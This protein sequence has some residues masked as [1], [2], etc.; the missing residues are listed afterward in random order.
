MLTPKLRELHVR[1]LTKTRDLGLVQTHLESE[2]WPKVAK[3]CPT[4]KK[5]R[6]QLMTL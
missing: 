1:P 5:G 6:T 2:Y 4:H 3:G